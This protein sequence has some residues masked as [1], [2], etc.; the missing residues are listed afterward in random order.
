L[1][2]NHVAHVGSCHRF[3]RRVPTRVD[4]DAP[5]PAGAALQTRLVGEYFN[6]LQAV[7]SAHGA[8]TIIRESLAQGRCTVRGQHK[9]GRVEV[10]AGQSILRSIK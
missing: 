7:L 4:F 6:R 10:I 1:P 9:Q 5:S 8:L 3:F 2:Q